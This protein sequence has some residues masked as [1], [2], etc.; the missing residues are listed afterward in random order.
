MKAK[1]IAAA[2]EA[3]GIHVLRSEEADE[4]TDGAVHITDLVH[5]S[6]PAYGSACWVVAECDGD[7]FQFYEKRKTIGGLVADIKTAMGLVPAA[8]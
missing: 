8:A 1:T 2:L 5:V 7:E 4:E 6:V 3:A